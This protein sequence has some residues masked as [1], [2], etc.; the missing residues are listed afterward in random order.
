[1][2]RAMP[3]VPY[4]GPGMDDYVFV[5]L[6]QR[7][8]KDRIIFMGEELDEETANQ[9]VSLLLQL[10]DEDAVSPVTMYCQ[11]PGGTYAGG[12][13]LYD[14]MQSMP[15]DIVTLNMGMAAGMGAFIVAGGTKGKRYALPNA[16]FLFQQ[17]SL[18]DE[19]NGPAEDVRTEVVNVLRQR[20]RWLRCLA[21]FCGRP[22]EA[23]V[24]DFRRDRY[25]T[26]PEARE[27]GLIDR[28][29]EPKVKGMDA[30]CG[31][32]CKGNEEDGWRRRVSVF[33]RQVNGLF[34]F[35]SIPKRCGYPRFVDCRASGR[36]RA[37]QNGRIVGGSERW[38]RFRRPRVSSTDRQTRHEL[39]AGSHKQPRR[40]SGASRWQARRRRRVGRGAHRP[41][42][43]RL[44]AAGNV[45]RGTLPAVP[46]GG[47]GVH[48]GRRAARSADA[49]T[50]ATRMLRRFRAVRPHAH[51]PGRSK[52][53]QREPTHCSR[54]CVQVLGGRLVRSAESQARRGHE[55]D[56]HRRALLY[57]GVAGVRHAHGPRR[58]S[59]G[60]RGD[61]Q[62]TGGVLDA[63][64][65]HRSTQL[66]GARG[67]LLANHGPHRAGR[68]VGC[69]DLLPLHAVRGHLLLARGHLPAGH[70]PAQGERAGARVLRPAQVQAQTGDP[71][72]PHDARSEAGTGENVQVGPGVGHLHGRQRG[73]SERQDQKGIL[74]AGR[75]GRQSVSGV[76]AVHGAAHTGLVYCGAE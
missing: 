33:S 61:Q 23:I 63:G 9:T 50:N 42:R 17:P 43:T 48:P 7:L 13:A 66:A 30:P 3:R 24:D 22:V 62:T 72:A 38:T 16:R 25:F 60:V 37:W 65:G 52:G 54:V 69:A 58:V 70:G 46:L 44:V 71:V 74:P 5:D 59:V 29:L 19:V 2:S 56:P 26:A 41:A 76:P 51:R 1:M 11:I 36:E 53:H 21:H 67:A 55:E 20:D 34:A 28:V 73:R 47:R 18:F 57:R 64:D 32:I 15:Y 6:M 14:C 45:A 31:R 75:G 8:N 39:A 49:Q 40:G 12:M 35:V 10:K 27:Y 68:A 4:K